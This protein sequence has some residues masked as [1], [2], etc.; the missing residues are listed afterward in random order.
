MSVDDLDERLMK[1]IQSGAD[2]PDRNDSELA[3]AIAVH[4]RLEGLFRILR[5]PATSLQGHEEQ[6]VRPGSQLGEFT[7][8]RRLGSGGMGTVFLARQATL[9]RLV[10]LKVC[11]PEIG[12]EQRLRERFLVEARAMAQLNHPQVAPVLLTGKQEGCLYIVM[13]YV[14][15]PTLA[16]V[17]QAVRSAPADITASAVVKEILAYPEQRPLCGCWSEGPATIDRG[18]RTW[19]VQTLEKVAGGLAAIHR[20]GIVHRDVKPSNVVLD[21]EGEPKIVD[22][23]LARVGQGPKATALGDFIGTPAYT[24]PEQA[25]GCGRYLACF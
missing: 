14:P 12:S 17:L 4:A 10:A 18:F 25:R 20:A 22:F 6:A 7:I 8:L 15:G 1:A 13:E 9:G 23:G 21:A 16:D 19:I 5:T 2:V 3:E 11:N 24:S